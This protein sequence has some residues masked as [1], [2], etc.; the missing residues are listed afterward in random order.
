MVIVYSYV[1]S[2]AKY[3]KNG[4]GQAGEALSRGKSSISGFYIT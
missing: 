4:A 1:K 3:S 2:P